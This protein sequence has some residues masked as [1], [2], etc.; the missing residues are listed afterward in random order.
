MVDDGGLPGDLRLGDFLPEEYLILSKSTYCA[1]LGAVLGN[2]TW[3]ASRFPDIVD[4]WLS[5]LQHKVA[6]LLKIVNGSFV[7]FV[8]TYTT[9]LP[10]S[11]NVEYQFMIGLLG[12]VSNIT[13]NPK[14]RE[15][16]ITNSDGKDFVYKIIKLMP[17]LPTSQASFPLKRLILMTLCN[18]S[19][20]KTGLHYLFQAKIGDAVNYCLMEN[21]LPENTQLLCLNIL[22]S[23]TYDLTNTEYIRDLITAISIERLENLTSSGNENI[24]VAAKQ[25]LEYLKNAEKFVS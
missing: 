15:F 23:I 24:S 21:S 14:G 8:D 16:L 25:I 18:V 6:E 9:V 20:N 2:L 11:G 17:A 13:A 22:Q 10:P 19:M 1:S 3:C 5:V 12:T 7:S 4:V